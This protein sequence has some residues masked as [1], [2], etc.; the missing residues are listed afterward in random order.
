MAESAARALP[1]EALGEPRESSLGRAWRLLRGKPLGLFGA[2]IVALMLLLALFAPVLSPYDPNEMFPTAVRR[3]PSI[4]YPLGT[5]NFGRDVWTRLVWGARTSMTVGLS[6]VTA[7]M[8]L[9]T[10]FGLVSGY[11]GGRIDFWLQRIMDILMGF[12]LL[13]KAMLLVVALGA[14]LFNVTLALAISLTPIANRVIRGTVLSIKENQYI[15]AA[16]AVGCRHGR[17]LFLHV[18]PNVMAPVIILFSLDIGTTILAEASLSFLG[19]GPPPPD[20]SWGRMLSG[21]GRS[22]YRYAPWLVIFPGL[23]ISL[24]VLGWNLVGDALRDIWDPRLR[25]AE[26]R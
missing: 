24:A 25:G 17:I 3:P 9:G 15:E 19:L 22:Q 5:D 6:A 12:P 10:F 1:L 20:A 7:A 2:V 14:S 16:A 11:F 23:F 4:N 21:E 26:H 18:L 8:A 13:I